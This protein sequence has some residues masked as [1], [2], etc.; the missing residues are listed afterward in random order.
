[1]SSLLLVFSSVIKRRELVVHSKAIRKRLFFFYFSVDIVSVLPIPQVC[2][3]LALVLNNIR[4]WLIR[5]LA[6]GGSNSRFKE[7]NDVSGVEGDL[8]DF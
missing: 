7:A 8:S 2:L 6:G 4:L 3:L 1:M 5:D